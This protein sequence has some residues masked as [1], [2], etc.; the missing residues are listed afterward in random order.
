VLLL[1]QIVDR[2][3]SG[4]SLLFTIR[5]QLSI[6]LFTVHSTRFRWEAHFALLRQ[7]PHIQN[8]KGIPTY[9]IST[10]TYAFCFWHFVNQ[11]FMEGNNPGAE[12]VVKHFATAQLFTININSVFEELIR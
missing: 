12:L 10:L 2:C 7:Q 6:A 4:C 1:N 3:Q 5:K 11:V 9:K 8:R